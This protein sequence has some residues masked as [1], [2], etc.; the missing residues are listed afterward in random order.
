MEQGHLPKLLVLAQSLSRESEGLG[1]ARCL[2]RSQVLLVTLELHQ[3]IASIASVLRLAVQTGA[4][5]NS[6]YHDERLSESSNQSEASE[7][8]IETEMVMEKEKER[9]RDK[10]KGKP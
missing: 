1:V 4:F 2:G 6:A 9:Q 5:S 7:K 10:A 3:E 8:E